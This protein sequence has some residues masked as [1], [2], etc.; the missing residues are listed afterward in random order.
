MQIV[1]G[2]P[3]DVFASADEKQMNMFANKSLIVNSSRKTLLT[4][5]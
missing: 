5:N 4:I 3:V 1:G 2:T